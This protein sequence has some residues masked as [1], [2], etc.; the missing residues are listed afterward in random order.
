MGNCFRILHT[1]EQQSRRQQHQHIRQ[2]SLSPRPSSKNNYEPSAPPPPKNY[3]SL[4]Q[5]N[6]SY[7]ELPDPFQQQ[8]KNTRPLIFDPY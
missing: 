8:P 5:T 1:Q 2:T 3:A 4:Q 7:L 6:T